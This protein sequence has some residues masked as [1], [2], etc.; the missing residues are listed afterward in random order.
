MISLPAG[1]PDTGPAHETLYAA[2][3]SVAVTTI[4]PSALPL[5]KAAVLV[6]EAL[7]ATG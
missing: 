4:V 7:S 6:A 5:H 2:V 3:P 1:L